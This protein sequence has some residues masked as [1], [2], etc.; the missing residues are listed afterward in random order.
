MSALATAGQ[1]L[2]P[3]IMQG[4]AYTP[5]MIFV[6]SS[7]W[8]L[9]LVALA[10][11]PVGRWP[12]DGNLD[13]ETDRRRLTGLAGPFVGCAGLLYCRPSLLPAFS[14]AGLTPPP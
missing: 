6:V 13:E 3:P 4:N 12:F 5:A 8:A 7:V 2:L 10:V 11:A 1:G 9:S 14:I